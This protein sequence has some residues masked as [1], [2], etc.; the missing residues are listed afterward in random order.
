MSNVI[1]YDFP[2]ASLL[3]F[4]LIP[5]IW[6][7]VLLQ[8]YR[9][10]INQ[11]YSKHSMQMG[12]M[13][14][15]SSVWIKGV[16]LL[17]IWISAVLALMQPKGNGRYSPEA[18]TLAYEEDRPPITQV[19][20]LLDASASMQVLDSR[21]GEA[22][23]EYAKDLLDEMARQLNGQN[24]SLWAFTSTATRLSPA[25]MDTLFL[26]LMI[27]NV[28]INEGNASGTSLMQAVKAIEKEMNEMPS[29]R[30]LTTILVSDGDDTEKGSLEEKKHMLQT[31]I[32]QV[33]GKFK[34]RLA[35]YSIGVG[36]AHG[37][38]VPNL[39]YQGKFVISKREDALLQTISQVNGMYIPV[40]N[41]SSDTLA[42]Q[43]T[44][45]IRSN[46]VKN[47]R[48]YATQKN[49]TWQESNH[50]LIY[51]LYYQFPLGFSLLF[52]LVELFFPMVRTQ[53]KPS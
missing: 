50:P 39:L 29:D 26:R 6:A 21:G 13:R 38:E 51:T 2:Q 33:L 35:I 5:I 52:L 40:E 4:L 24:A 27:R 25:T 3:M 31:L 18:I 12:M 23:I 10:R 42:R 15:L 34:E 46:Q 43:I 53:E 9:S 37:G 30:Y 41:Q 16:L 11:A 7:L 8:S 48:E 44:D 19:Q 22:R 14:E 1:L 32:D 36:S 17:L 47:E 20:F 45:R 49:K 28:A